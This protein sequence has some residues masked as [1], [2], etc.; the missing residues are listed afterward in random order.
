MSINKKDAKRLSEIL[1]KLPIEDQEFILDIFGKE[2]TGDFALKL[3]DLVGDEIDIWKG[4][5]P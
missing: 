3:L 4:K 1:M 5:T 2:F